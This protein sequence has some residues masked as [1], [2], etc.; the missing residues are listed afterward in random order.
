MVFMDF[1]YGFFYVSFIPRRFPVRL[2]KGDVFI[3]SCN[4][5]R[6]SREHRCPR[7]CSFA[8]HAG[9][10]YKPDTGGTVC[11]VQSYDSHGA[12]LAI[13]LAMLALFVR[14]NFALRELPPG[15]AI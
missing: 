13:A 6:E 8:L 14:R 5:F 11:P 15:Q 3:D 9:W 7:L 4:G 12:A 2:R 10:Y 1:G